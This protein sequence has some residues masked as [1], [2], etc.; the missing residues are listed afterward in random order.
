MKKTFWLIIMLC[1]CLCILVACNKEQPFEKQVYSA[2]NGEDTYEFVIEDASHYT[3]THTWINGYNKTVTIDKGS[4]TND[5]KVYTRT[6][7][8]EHVYEYFFDFDNPIHSYENDVSYEPKHYAQILTDRVIAVSDGNIPVALDGNSG[9]DDASIICLY[10]KERK[11][12]IDTKVALNATKE[13]IAKALNLRIIYGDL[14]TNHVALSAYNI[15]DVDT[16]TL[17]TK[18]VHISYFGK[19]YDA[20]I[21]VVESGL[22]KK[23]DIGGLQSIV[24]RGTSARDYVRLKNIVGE[25]QKILYDGQ[26]INITSSM[27]KNFNANDIGVSTFTVEVNGVSA[28]K[29]IKVYDPNGNRVYDRIIG[30]EFVDGKGVYNPVSTRTT[31]TNPATYIKALT[32]L[33]LDGTITSLEY[34][35]R[36]MVVHNLMDN[37]LG[38]RNATITFTN[39]TNQFTYVQ[40]FYFYDPLDINEIMIS[41]EMKYLSGNDCAYV[42]SGNLVLKSGSD[43]VA[44]KTTVAGQTPK[45]VPIR[46]QMITHY[47]SLRITTEGL[48]FVIPIETINKYG[49]YTFYESILV[50]LKETE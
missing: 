27:I 48:S 46:E 20:I 33:K 18:N 11:N 44:Y 49:T 2:T 23:L 34:N 29:K 37:E 16:S 10:N 9:V 17:G 19:T 32:L 15:G 5:G 3:L 28:E 36:T 47:S 39:L 22:E 8:S 41:T 7:E 50:K 45:V 25:D 24:P 35:A 38:P 43:Y 31:I 21:E 14:Y 1:L 40:P 30:V 13:D 12:Q 42:E 26:E 6:P 4:Y